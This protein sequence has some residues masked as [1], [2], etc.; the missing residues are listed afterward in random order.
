MKFTDSPAC[1][2]HGHCVFCRQLEAGRPWRSKLGEIY[3]LPKNLVDFPCPENQPFDHGQPGDQSAPP[4]V[5]RQRCGG[6]EAT[7]M[8]LT[9]EEQEAFLRDG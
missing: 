6:C 5:E 8:P 4:A 1:K 2:G 9:P 3:E 7:K